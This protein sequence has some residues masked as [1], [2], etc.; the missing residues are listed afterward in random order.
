MT[1]ENNFVNNLNDIR[2]KSEKLN[3]NISYSY[4]NT[5]EIKTNNLNTTNNL[6]NISK[7]VIQIIKILL[8]QIQIIN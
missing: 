8:N 4:I 3:D 6:T 7:K 2:S 5:N 1:E